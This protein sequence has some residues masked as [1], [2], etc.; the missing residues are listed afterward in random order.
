MTADG[1]ASRHNDEDSQESRAI[2]A[3]ASVADFIARRYRPQGSS[4][5][6]IPAPERFSGR[7]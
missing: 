1:E 2:F 5:K 6:A 4:H 3:T 7:P